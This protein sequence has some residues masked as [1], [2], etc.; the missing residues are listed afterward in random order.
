EETGSDDKQQGSNDAASASGEGNSN[1][2]DRI[3]VIGSYGCRLLQRRG[4]LRQRERGTVIVEGRRRAATLASRLR[5][6]TTDGRRGLAAM[7][8]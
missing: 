3:A 7:G 1:S 5:L 8:H 6:Q 2:G 4:Q